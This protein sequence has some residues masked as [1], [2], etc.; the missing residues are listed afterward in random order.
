ME[1][2]TRVRTQLNIAPDVPVV[3]F[4][5]KLLPFKRPLDLIAAAA[6]AK[7]KGNEIT[8]LVAGAGPLQ[9]EVAR[10]AREKGVLCHV[11]GFRNQSEMPETYAA[12]DLLVLPSEH[13]TW[14]LVA[15]EALA[16]GRPIVLSDTVGSAPDLALDQTVGRVFPLGDVSALADAICNLL[17]H[18][19]SLKVIAS[20]SNAYSPAVAANGVVRAAEYALRESTLGE[21]LGSRCGSG[22]PT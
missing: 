6:V 19:P 20:K 21:F 16:C 5:G 7:A 15:N 13:E 12:S 18:K 8:V 11:L 10:F 3:L 17:Q 9:D 14:G 1:A 2:R 22:D 4:A